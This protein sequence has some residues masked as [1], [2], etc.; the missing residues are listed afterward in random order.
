MPESASIPPSPRATVHATASSHGWPAAIRT[1]TASPSWS[2]G[3]SP[4]PAG[5]VSPSPG[6]G[7]SSTRMPSKASRTTV[8]GK[9]AS[10]MRVLEPPPSTNRGSPAASAARTAS[11]A[12]ASVRAVTHARAGPPTRVVV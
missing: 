1:T 10:A 4:S 6:A 2:A 12:S 3:R 8:P 11:I 7:P 5:G 9:P